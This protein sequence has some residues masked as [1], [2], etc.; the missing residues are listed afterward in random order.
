M[1]C[2]DCDRELTKNEIG[3]NKKLLGMQIKDFFCIDCL[4][5]YLDCDV[6]EL[7]AKI[8]QFKQEG[9]TLFS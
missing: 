8:E 1:Q 9:C 3:I 2:C 4:A 5:L 7:Y 6:E